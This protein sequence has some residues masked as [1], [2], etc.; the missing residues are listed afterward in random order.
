MSAESRQREFDFH[1]AIEIVVFALE[2][3][4]WLHIDDYVQVA[5]LAAVDAR[6]AHA[7]FSQARA[8][9]DACGDIHPQ[10]RAL[11][12]SARP[13]TFR[14][15]I[16]HYG[17]R[18]VA[19]GTRLGKAYWPLPHMHLARAPALRARL[20][21]LAAFRTR[22]VAIGTLDHSIVADGLADSLCCVFKRYLYLCANIGA[23]FRLV[24]IAL[25]RS[26]A[27][28][29]EKVGKYAATAA[30]YFAK[31]VEGIKIGPVRS[32]FGALAESVVAELIVFCALIRIG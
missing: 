4:V 18:T 5:I 21:A 6:V 25:T 29:A 24:K 11:S 31:D 27:H 32:A 26:A 20:L 13:G 8:R 9:I 3:L 22:T 1:L 17:A 7:R 28:S 15:R 12:N 16:F 19:I 10:F 2:S 30:E 23:V 14:A